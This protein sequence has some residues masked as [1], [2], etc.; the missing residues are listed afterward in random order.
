M[1]N[2]EKI[3][4]HETAVKSGDEYFNN[5]DM[6]ANIFIDKYALRDDNGNLLEKNPEDMHWRLASEFARIESGKFKKPL[7]KEEIF[8][9]FDRFKFII[10]GGSPMSGIGNKFYLQS[11][12]NCFVIPKPLDSY[13]GI[14]YTDQQLVQLMK[15]RG[16]VGVCIDNI[17]PRGLATKNSA[18]T[19]DGIL[20]FMKRY[21]NSCKEVAQG[22]RRGAELIGLSVHHP[23]IESFIDA[24]KD[25]KSI[26]GANV[27]VKI[28]DEFMKA[29]K[30]DKEYELRWPVD[31]KTPR[32]SIMISARKIWDKIIE[33][34]WS[35]AEPGMLF[36]DTIK[37]YGLSDQYKVKNNYFEDILS[38]PCG[39][40]PMG[41]D[42]CRLLSENLL[43]FVKNPYTKDAYFDY[44][45]FDE[46]TV[47]AQRLLDDMIDL[48]IECIE[49]ILEKI[50]SDPEPDHIKQLE[51]ETWELFKENCELGRRTGLGITSMGDTFAALGMKY[52]SPESIKECNKIFKQ[53]AISSMK[54]SCLMAKELG[55]FPLYDKNIEKN[56]LF[57]E[58]IFEA[59]E[60]VKDL[61]SKYGRRNISLTTIAPTGSVSCLTQTS[62]GIEPVI[63][64]S[65]TRKRKLN[66]DQIKDQ[67]YTIDE[68][69]DKWEE[70]I[71]NHHGLNRWMEITGE[72]DI[73][74]SPYYGA[75]SKDIDWLASVEIQATAQKWISHSI[76][77]TANLPKDASKELVSEIYMKAW[78]SKCKGFTIYREGSRDAVIK[79]NA[80]KEEKNKIK[81]KRTDAPKRP[82][83][84]DCEVYHVKI[85]KRLDKQRT[86]EYIVAIGLFEGEPYEVFAFENGKLDKK[87]TYGKTV[88]SARGKYHIEF[89][90]GTKLLDITKD[91][92]A[93]EEIITRAFSQ[94]LRHGVPVAY[95]V[96]QIEKTREEMTSFVK[97][98]GRALKKHIKEGERVSGEECEACAKK[99]NKGELI[100]S[101]G[102]V[103]CLICG[104]SK[105]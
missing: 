88:K 14:L 102:C 17:R 32:I 52:G 60:E 9:Y 61:H 27:S 3:I 2:N 66:N 36:I 45:L 93:D 38:N 12:G 84:L 31:S 6:A 15:R 44:E 16:G 104:W 99:G 49:R 85:T 74:K 10:P 96:Q 75:T 59:S 92:T 48:E 105:C 40:I 98:I 47:I 103:K 1:V 53:F 39:E 30:A 62:S 89:E 67:K 72:T 76:S 54:S 8:S 43:S 50:K 4:D 35:V 18:K 101:D 69:G 70:N 83:S 97:S 90:D 87:Y 37:Q 55:A 63:F 11:L 91:Q 7:S 25:L 23:E 13:G 64:L 24:K 22:G 33:N 95:L 80:V 86:L 21:S 57:L 46:V 20:V 79:D 94:E 5:D 100:R 34:A 71:I 58:R 78:E 82:E 68:H 73:K 77:K 26:T 42:S 51:K 28:T 29:V 56:H 81:I 41:V 65:Y 19:T